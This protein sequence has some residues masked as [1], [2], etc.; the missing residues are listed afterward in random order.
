M[1]KTICV[2]LTIDGEVWCKIQVD[3]TTFPFLLSGCAFVKYT[4]HP[5]AQ[6]AIGALHG[7]QTMAVSRFSESIITQQRRIGFVKKNYGKV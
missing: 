1:Y 7:S 4:G 6:N 2:I 5:E 3:W